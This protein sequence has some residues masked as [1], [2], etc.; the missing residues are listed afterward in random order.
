MFT[1][2]INL[3]HKISSHHLVHFNDTQ[4]SLILLPIFLFI[5]T[6]LWTFFQS[7][8]DWLMFRG[9]GQ[10]HCWCRVRG[11]SVANHFGV[12]VSTIERLVRHLRETGHLAD[13]PQSGRPCV[14][15]RRQDRTIRLA[16][17]RNPH[18]TATETAL[19]TVGTHNRQISP[20]T[21]GSRLREIGL[22]AHRPY[23]GLPLT[24]APSLRHMA[25]LTAHAPRLFPM[26]QWRRV[27]F[28]DESRFTLYHAYG[29]CRVYRRR[30][31]RFADACVVEQDRFEGVS[32]MVWGGIAH[33]IK[34]QLII[35]AGNMTAVRYR[36]EILH[37]VAVP[38][39]Q[40]R[41]LFL[42]QDNSQPHV[43]RVCQ[44]FLANNNIAPLAWPPYSPD[45]TPIEHTWDELDRRV[46]KLRN[47]PATL[48]QLRNALI[49]EWNN[50]PM[51]TV[52]ALVNS[53][54]RRIRAATAA[55]GGHNRYWF[56][57]WFWFQ[58]LWGSYQWTSI[59]QDL[60]ITNQ[61]NLELLF[62]TCTV[63]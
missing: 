28:T 25:W 47:P 60:L 30:G 63:L 62:H 31:E 1:I 14:T 33:G 42:Q 58:D 54:Q 21:V 16:H 43:A 23:L 50:I 34:S 20:K 19:N 6:L 7:W 29:W 32:V 13:W 26:R 46:R 59:T 5:F 56:S 37:P 45:L 15:S 57:V 52:N 44:D 22:R 41:N 53:I 61:W 38:L 8:Y 51:L 27:L 9:V 24:Q 35:V 17:L 4:R 18:F 40:Q 10:L 48:V 3:Q 12:N 49:N 2:A 36:D 55:R 11:N 39:V